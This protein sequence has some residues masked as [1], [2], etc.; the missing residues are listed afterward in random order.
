MS[1]KYSSKLSPQPFLVYAPSNLACM[2]M[3]VISISKMEIF[4]IEF[5]N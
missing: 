2:D 5:I 3:R 1:L 4:H